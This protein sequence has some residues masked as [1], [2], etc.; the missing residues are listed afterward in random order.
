MSFGAGPSTGSGQAQG[1]F[2]ALLLARS[3]TL[4]KRKGHPSLWVPLSASKW[5]PGRMPKGARV[6]WDDAEIRMKRWA[7]G[8]VKLVPQH[9]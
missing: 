4:S 1:H 8:R 7:R 9:P 2:S 6:L 5:L 3:E